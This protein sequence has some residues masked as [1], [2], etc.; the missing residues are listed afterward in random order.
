MSQIPGVGTEPS[1]PAEKP[2]KDPPAMKLWFLLAPV[3]VLILLILLL[4]RKR[5][6]EDEN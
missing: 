5:K 1:A 6:K 3:A 4:L 2:E